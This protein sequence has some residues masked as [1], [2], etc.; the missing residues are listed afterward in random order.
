MLMMKII[1]DKAKSLRAPSKD[2]S[3]PLTKEDKALLDKMLQHLKDSQDPEKRERNPGL[4]EGVGLAAPQ[5]GVNKKMLVIHYPIQ[6]E[7]GAI[8]YVSHQLV[9]PRIT[10]SSVKKCYLAGGEGCLSVPDPHEGRVY[11]DYRVTVKAFDALKNEEIEV[12]AIGYDAIVLQH[13]IDHLSGILFYD[14]IDKSNPEKELP[15]AIAI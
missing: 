2:V 8:E 15:G 12:R 14:R 10:R 11:R 6:M 3:L 1:S 4:R 9:N 5:V 13:E 7:D